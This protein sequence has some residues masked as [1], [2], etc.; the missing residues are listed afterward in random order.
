MPRL[1]LASFRLFLLLLAWPGRSAESPPSPSAPPLHTS[2]EDVKSLL[3]SM[4]AKIVEIKTSQ[5]AM[6]SKLA[7][8]A[9]E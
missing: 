1:R 7:G 8:L 3:A 9:C 2:F 4:D 5:T 6:E